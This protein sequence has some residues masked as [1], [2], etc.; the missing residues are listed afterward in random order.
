MSSSPK[1]GNI[2]DIVSGAIE[3]TT[4]PLDSFTHHPCNSHPPGFV[5]QSQLVQPEVN[6]LNNHPR[7]SHPPDFDP[8]AGQNDPPIEQPDYP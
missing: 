4:S 3:L 8:L 6:D 5:P 1:F 2:F 7:N